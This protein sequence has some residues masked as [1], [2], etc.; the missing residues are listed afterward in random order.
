MFGGFSNEFWTSYHQV[1]PKE[2][3]FEQRHQLYQLYHYVN[4]MN[5]FGTGYKGSCMK[6]L[7]NL[8]KYV[9]ICFKSELTLWKS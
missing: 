8:L 4:H 7:R 2:K 3:G 9:I 6:I 5:I 1:I